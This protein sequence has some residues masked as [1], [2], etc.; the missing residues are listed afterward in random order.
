ML[1]KC[2]S[3]GWVQSSLLPQDGGEQHP[4]CVIM[5]VNFVNLAR[6][7]FSQILSQTLF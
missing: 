7:W 6:L 5:I 2:L 4:A 3:Q 1:I